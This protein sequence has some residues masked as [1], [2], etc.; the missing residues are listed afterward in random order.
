MEEEQ[1]EDEAQGEHEVQVEEKRVQKEEQAQVEE[2]EPDGSNYNQVVNNEPERKVLQ[3][4][5]DRLN[6][7]LHQNVRIAQQQRQEQPLVPPIQQ[8]EGV[9]V[10]NAPKHV[11]NAAENS[12][13]HA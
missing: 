8:P 11:P 5:Q 1:V 2:Q 12:A 9:A 3:D 13:K 6:E 10:F 7:W 4:V